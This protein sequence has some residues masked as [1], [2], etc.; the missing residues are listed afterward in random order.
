MLS[1]VVCSTLLSFY[2][3]FDSWYKDVLIV[4]HLFEGSSFVN[5]HLG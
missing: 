5:A 1:V 2:S 4:L 3:H